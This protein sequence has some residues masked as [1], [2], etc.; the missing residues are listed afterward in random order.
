[1]IIK[2]QPLP[3]IELINPV[4][5]VCRSLRSSGDQLQEKARFFIKIKVAR[6]K[7]GLSTLLR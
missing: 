6:I 2:S 5:R 1:M 7:N 4:R 3:S